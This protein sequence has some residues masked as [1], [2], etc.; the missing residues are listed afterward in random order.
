M[1]AD[2]AR[3]EALARAGLSNAAIA[4][5][6]GVSPQ[7]V[8]AIIRALGITREQRGEAWSNR[9]G[10]ASLGVLV[11]A[12]RLRE[13]RSA[14]ARLAAEA[15]AAGMSVEKVAQLMGVPRSTVYDLLRRE[16]SGD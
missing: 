9:L 2:K 11:A 7:R 12:R 4:R 8:G 10:D 15:V 5:E 13:K 3:V 6:V 14:L 16:R 1:G